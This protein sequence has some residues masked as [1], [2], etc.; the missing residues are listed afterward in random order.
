MIGR[1]A[2]PGLTAGALGIAA[3]LIGVAL[4]TPS[5]GA[6]AGVLALAAGVAGVRTARQLDDQAGARTWS[7]RRS[8]PT[9]PTSR[10]LAWNAF[11]SKPPAASASARRSRMACSPTL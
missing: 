4:E 9:E 7:A 10:T 11:G 8:S 5:F 1:A 6:V 2:L 3:G